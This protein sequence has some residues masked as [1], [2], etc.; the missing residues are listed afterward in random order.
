VESLGIPLAVGK[1][2]SHFTESVI[3]EM[4]RLSDQYDAINLSQGMPDFDPPSQLIEAA[5]EAMRH[6]SNQYSVTW[7]ERSLR[8]AISE[9]VK[10]YNRI[11]AD[12]ER[13][14]TITC[15]ST[16]AVA[17]AVLGL[18]DPGDRVVVTDPFYENYVPD[19]II[20]G[21]ELVYAPF[22][23]RNLVLDEE[24]LKKAMDSN[25]KLII[26]NTP[27]NP[28]GRVLDRDQLKL[29]ADLCEEKG[30]IA[31]VD[32]IYEHIL[33]EGRQ[34]ISLASIG[35]MHERTVTVSGAS[36]TYSVTGWRVGWATAEATLTDAIRKVHDYLSICA[37]HPFQEALV[38]ALNF[39]RTYY[40]KLAEMYDKKRRQ[41]LKSLDEA[42]IEYHRP[43]G[44]YYV[45]A[46]A[47]EKYKDGQ[48]FAEHLLK[49]AGVAV[50]PANALYHNKQ[51]GQRKI[52]FA[53]CKKDATLQ[54]VGRRLKKLSAKS[55]Q[56]VAP[57]A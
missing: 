49:D 18:I 2:L 36:K 3:R 31:I 10:E 38:T 19:A 21:A 27:N 25:P 23:R 1:R 57:K 50:L 11:D 4:T 32:E 34:H 26:L 30:A 40:D 37:P 15:G 44:A 20:A 22:L 54:D 48:D 29:I 56:K 43:E 53:F 7:G 39:P 14:I 42:E 35:N 51:L 55:K 24:G 17:S 33:Y 41:L 45:L 52:R 8:E 13:N 12:P 47:P 16:E 6:E 28:T 9:K 46:N 5:V